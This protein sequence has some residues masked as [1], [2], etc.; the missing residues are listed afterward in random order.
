MITTKRIAVAIAAL[1]VVAAGCSSADTAAT[2]NDSD[3]PESAVLA[4]RVGNEGKTSVGAEEFRNDLSRLIFSEAMLT[5]AEE[6][7]GLTGLDSPEA[8]ADY[9]TTVGAQEQQYLA[10][11]VEDQTL[12]DAA[13][14]V[15]VTQ[16]VLRSEIR[17]ALAAEEEVLLDVWQNDR[18]QL[19]EV[20][21]SHILVATEE[22][23]ETVRARLE[24]G[25]GFGALANEVSLD[26]QSVDGVL[27]CPVSPSVFVVDF[28]NA[29]AT[30]P[31]GEVV[32]PVQSDFGFHIVIVESRE[33]PQTLEELAE[34]PVR[35]M[36]SETIDFYWN[37]WI[38]DVVERAD[39]NVRSDI[40]TWYPPVDG[41]I[42]PPPSP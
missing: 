32:G 34:D 21:A 26:A 13:F 39:I 3:I 2:V 12:S 40:G 42:P 29:V 14:D 6:D 30:A 15:V 35:W 8:R 1:S 22:E 9:L 16:L 36:P 38:N 20:C 18:H 19:I 41:I 7:F 27:P 25:E 33:S 24:A 31:V 28:A 17:A 4:I 11:I 37:V 5:A 23:A 10:S